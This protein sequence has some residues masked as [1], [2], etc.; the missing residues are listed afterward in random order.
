MP[1]S[2]N[3]IL[4]AKVGKQSDRKVQ[5]FAFNSYTVESDNIKFLGYPKHFYSMLNYNRQ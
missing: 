3:D 2:Q 5:M 4:I 1:M